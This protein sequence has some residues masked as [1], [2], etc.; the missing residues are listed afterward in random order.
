[1]VTIVKSP[2][3]PDVEVI[4]SDFSDNPFLDINYIKILKDLINQDENS[5]RIYTLGQWGLVQ[6]RIFTNY[7][8]IPELPLIDGGHWAYGLDFGL[9][10]PTA[11]VKVHLLGNRFYLEERLYKT[12]L[13]NADIIE[14]F[15][16]EAKGDIYGDPS[17]KMM[18]EEIRR[19][20]FSAYEGHKGVK[21]SIDLMQRQELLI[22]QSSSNLIKEINSYQWKTNK[23]G[24]V[25]PEPVK[26]ND[27]AIDAARYAIWGITERY[28]FP[29][30]RPHSSASIS[31]LTFGSDDSLLAFP[32]PIAVGI[33]RKYAQSK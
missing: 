32:H 28:G 16:H 26:W 23:E 10:N 6:R 29:T 24:A 11:I 14:F 21:E 25:L 13:T 31:T 2:V 33:G 1:M 4:Y 20:G 27:H 12:N 22:P 3:D 30:Q 19:A 7:K 9:V 8:I 15:S 18:I 17:S 5:Y